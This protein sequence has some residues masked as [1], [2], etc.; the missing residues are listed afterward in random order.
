MNANEKKQQLGL[1]YLL[2]FIDVQLEPAAGGAALYALM[3]DIC[4]EVGFRIVGGHL[5][6]FTDEAV[7]P[8]GFASVLC[9]DQSHLSAHC[10]SDRGILACD[11]FT[12]GPLERCRRAGELLRDGV[13]RLFPGARVSSERVVDRFV[14]PETPLPETPLPA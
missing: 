14:L 12:C 2:D 5:E 7:S 1:H 13:L 10:Y 9:I 11:A 3:R 4:A 8:P 6:V